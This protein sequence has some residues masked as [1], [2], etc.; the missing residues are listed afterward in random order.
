MPTA[1]TIAAARPGRRVWCSGGPASYRMSL[2]R[3]RVALLQKLGERLFGAFQCVGGIFVAHDRE[4]DLRPQLLL[5]LGVDRRVRR[6]SSLATGKV[7][8]GDRSP[9][10]LCRTI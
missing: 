1:Q 10:V 3:S 4:L 6:G 9:L 8:C 2:I 5:E 7:L